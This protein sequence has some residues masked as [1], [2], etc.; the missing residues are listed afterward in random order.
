M[1]VL[2][3]LLT[4]DPEL[5]V[6]P[7]LYGG[8][9]RIVAGLVGELRSRGHLVGLVAHGDSTCPV[10]R[11]YSWPCLKPQTSLAHTRNLWTLLRAASDFQADLVHSFSRLGYLLPLL[12]RRLPKVMSYQRST[13]GRQ[14]V[15]GTRLGGR[16]LRFTGCSQFIADMGARSGGRW[17]A[18]PNFVELAKF[19]FQ[20]IV[21]RE[22]PLVFLSRV[23]RI[24]GT[25]V[26]I[27][28]AKRTRRRLL[29]AGNHGETGEE[30]RYWETE[31]LPHL[32]KNGIEYVGPVDDVQKNKLLGLAGAMIVPIE[33]DE[34]FGIVFIEA[35]ACGTPVISC[36][37][38]A[39]PEI[40]RDHIDGFLTSTVDEA[41]AAILRLPAID[42]RECRRR[43]ELNFSA[44]LIATQYEALYRDLENSC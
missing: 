28:V 3:I 6:P 8:I 23:E 37:R 4:V 10:E 40:V 18:I 19:D 35:M 30:G 41:C 16:T 38:G 29:I 26:A 25:H 20:P 9:E 14:I 43:V 11:L 34:P 5:P 27:A 2:R 22:A 44:S 17:D 31:I 7:K 15:W 24:K 33:W 12:P 39:L 13:G 21:L 36:P 32:G 1:K 42:R